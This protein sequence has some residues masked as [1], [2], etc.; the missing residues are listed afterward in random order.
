MDCQIG[1]WHQWK[2]SLCRDIRSSWKSSGSSNKT[3]LPDSPSL[4]ISLCF[5]SSITDSSP[6]AFPSTDLYDI[7]RASIKIFFSF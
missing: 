5:K 6:E 3:L 2:N 4:F 7:I 1:R